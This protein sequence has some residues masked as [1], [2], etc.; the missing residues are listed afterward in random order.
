MLEQCEDWIANLTIFSENY[1]KAEIDRNANENNEA[2]KMES[3]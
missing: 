1:N 3:K 2:N